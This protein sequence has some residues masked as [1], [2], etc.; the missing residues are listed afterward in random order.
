MSIDDLKGLDEVTRKE[1]EELEKITREK[2]SS[3]S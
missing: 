2:D 1:I 3:E